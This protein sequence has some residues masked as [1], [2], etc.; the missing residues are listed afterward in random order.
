M[1][2]FL[3]I[4]ITKSRIVASIKTH[5]FNLK[6]VLKSIF[7]IVKN[8]EFFWIFEPILAMQNNVRATVK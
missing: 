3:I 1:K 8:A 2:L 4:L 6:K 7:N 5:I